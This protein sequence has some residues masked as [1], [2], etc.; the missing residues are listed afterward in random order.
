[1]YSCVFLDGLIGYIRGL[2]VE[3]NL[4]LGSRL[5]GSQISL[6]ACCW[7]ALLFTGSCCYIMP[8]RSRAF[9]GDF[10]LSP[11]LVWQCQLH[12]GQ[13]KILSSPSWSQPSL[14]L[15]TPHRPDSQSAN[16]QD[17][18][19]QLAPG[20][21]NFQSTSACHCLIIPSPTPAPR[22]TMKCMN[23]P[24]MNPV[25][26]LNELTYPLEWFSAYCH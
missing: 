15:Q 23:W 20:I 26:M 10:N 16:L 1:M 3:T 4:F 22:Y 11:V 7:A 8:T 24:A 12:P 21:V 18:D 14:L 6:Q 2:C 5:A 19:L 17:A 9:P 25:D 13:P